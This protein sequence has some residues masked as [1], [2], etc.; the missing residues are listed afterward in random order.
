MTQDFLCL[1]QSYFIYVL[2][3]FS[4]SGSYSKICWSVSLSLRP[5]CSFISWYITEDKS[6][7]GIKERGGLGSLEEMRN[8]EKKDHNSSGGTI[9]KQGNR[10]FGGGGNKSSYKLPNQKCF[11]T[12]NTNVWAPRFWDRTRRFFIF[13]GGAF[14]IFF[15]VSLKSI[16][17]FQS[18][19][20]CACASELVLLL[21][22]CVRAF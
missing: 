1:I 6:K 12:D 10:E 11:Y 20:V 9:S 5:K 14:F 19:F 15:F 2:F 16:V 22:W 18:G 13:F 7:S 21:G 17:P 3:S 4:C 8:D